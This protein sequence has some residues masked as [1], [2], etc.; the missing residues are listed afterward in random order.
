MDEEDEQQ[1]ETALSEQARQ[2]PTIT[3]ILL[4]LLAAPFL[5]AALIGL[6]LPVVPQLIPA[7]IGLVLLTLASDA[8]FGFLERHLAPRAPKTWKRMVQFRARIRRL[9]S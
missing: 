2:L 1:Q 4:A 5:V 3:R 7:V 9:L 8:F 6:A